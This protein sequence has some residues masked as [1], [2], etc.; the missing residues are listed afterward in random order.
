M[1]SVLRNGRVVIH[2]YPRHHYA[3]YVASKSVKTPKEHIGQ[4]GLA[5]VFVLVIS[6]YNGDPVSNS[7]IVHPSDH[8]SAFVEEALNMMISGAVQLGVQVTFMISPS[9]ANRLSDRPKSESF[10]FPFLVVKMF[11]ALR[12]P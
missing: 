12:F 9:S 7:I 1:R 4:E 11:A 6:P 8:I 2:N 5:P 3:Y 10:T